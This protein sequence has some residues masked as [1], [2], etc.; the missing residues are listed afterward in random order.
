METPSTNPISIRSSKFATIGTPVDPDFKR[1]M[2]FIS[3]L[4]SVTFLLAAY[5]TNPT[6]SNFRAY[7]EQRL[8][9][10]QRSTSGKKGFKKWMP[11]FIKSAINSGLG[12]NRQSFKYRNYHLFS[13]VTVDDTL[14]VFI[15]IFGV[16]MLASKG[17]F[18]QDAQYGGSLKRSASLSE[19][20]S[21]DAVADSLREKAIKEKARK[22]YEAAGDYFYKAAETL[23]Q[24]PNNYNKIEAAL[25]Y[26]DASKCFQITQ[27][28]SR[29]ISCLQQAV[30]HDP[31]S[32]RSARVYETLS[33]M[34]LRHIPG[35]NLSNAID[36]MIKSAQCYQ[37][38]SDIRCIFT[39][40]KVAELEALAGEFDKALMT[41]QNH[42]LQSEFFSEAMKYREKEVLFFQGLCHIGNLNWSELT[43]WLDCTKQKHSSFCETR[44]Y[45]F[46]LDLSSSASSSDPDKWSDT[47]SEFVKIS[48]I[49]EPW[50]LNALRKAK[51]SAHVGIR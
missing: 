20:K 39:W 4:I 29:V 14:E 41:N 19:I 9:G 35:D 51:P 22:N 11:K 3:L 46:L 37:E 31:S 32:T 42:V 50:K 47:I 45:Q 36:F 21:T 18:D 2:S 1:K 44:E 17:S 40:L 34:Y 7:L 48:P 6:D 12:G 16:W 8:N 23:Q 5:H 43:K 15:G 49:I 26:E 38:N 10:E 13:V 30:K 27:N 28:Y 25:L 33:T 24:S